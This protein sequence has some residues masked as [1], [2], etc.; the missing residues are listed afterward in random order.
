MSLCYLYVVNLLVFVLIKKNVSQSE[1]YGTNGRGGRVLGPQIKDLTIHMVWLCTNPQFF[2]EVNYSKS[3]TLKIIT[4]IVITKVI[5]IKTLSAIKTSIFDGLAF[6]HKSD[7][8]II[9]PRCIFQV[10]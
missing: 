4:P 3:Q 9:Y 5:K 7:F 8:L 2:L 1:P 6:S 10:W